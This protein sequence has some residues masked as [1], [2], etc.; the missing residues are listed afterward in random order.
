LRRAVGASERACERIRRTQNAGINSGGMAGTESLDAIAGVC[1]RRVPLPAESVIESKVR[2]QFPGVLG[3]EG[4][5]RGADIHGVGRTLDIRVGETEEIVGDE[6][7]VANVVRPAAIEVET[8]AYVVKV[9]LMQALIADVRSEFQG[10]L[11]HD[12]A[13]GVHALINVS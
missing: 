11:A 3:E 9:H 10:M 13:V 7:A 8:A 6:A 1:L 12:S 2:L 5:L 4:K